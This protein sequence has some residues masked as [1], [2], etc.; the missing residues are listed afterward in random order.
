V[1][2]I[3]PKAPSPAGGVA[4]PFPELAV[5]LAAASSV[6][7]TFLAPG[8]LRTRE[9]HHPGPAAS[10]SSPAEGEMRS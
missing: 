7:F 9:T 8:A 6:F 1:W 10:D 4:T 2:H 5:V 3:A